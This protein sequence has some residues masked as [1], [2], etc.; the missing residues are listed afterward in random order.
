MMKRFENKAA[1]APGG[2]SGIG[3][4]AAK[5]SANNGASIVV[6]RIERFVDGGEAK[7]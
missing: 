2:T 6:N 3:P 1:I 5:A 4:A 7:I